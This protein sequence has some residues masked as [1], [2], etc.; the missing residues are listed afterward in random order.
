MDISEQ[1]NQWINNRHHWDRP[2]SG[3][4]ITTQTHVLDKLNPKVGERPWVALENKTDDITI[5]IPRTTKNRRHH[6]DVFSARMDNPLTSKGWWV[7]SAPRDLSLKTD[8]KDNWQPF[9]DLKCPESELKKIR[10]MLLW[11]FEGD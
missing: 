4:I 11:L 9:R 6:S 7:V 8:E 10:E 1:L 5:I 2:S 3:Q